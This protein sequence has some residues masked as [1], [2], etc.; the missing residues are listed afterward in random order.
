[1]QQL[2]DEAMT[3]EKNV[4]SLEKALDIIEIVSNEQ[5]DASLS[6]IA[7]QTGLPKSTVHRLI[8]TLMGRGYLEKTEAGSYKIGLKLFEAVSCY[9]NNLELQTEAR[10]YIAELTSH[11][12]LTSYLGVLDG[13]EV[14]YIEKLDAVSAMKMYYQIGSRMHAYCSSLGKCLLSNYSKAQLDVILED[15]SFIKFTPN[16]IASRE[17]LDAEIA[18]VR[19]Q[20]WAMDNE[21]CEKG[22][23]CIGAPIFDYKGDIIAAVSASGDKRVLTDDRIEEVAEAVMK[24]AS[25]I[26][27]RMGY[28]E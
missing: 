15:C 3:E 9:I 28:V 4:K 18:K 6:E 7:R 19:K 14:V 21:E 13:D 10:P 8:A 12:G 27:H 2:G 16:T 23:R 24:A 17:E 22:H 20:G 25:R 11:L 5:Q 1:M 26:S